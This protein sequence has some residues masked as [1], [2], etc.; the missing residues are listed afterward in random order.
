M[1]RGLVAAVLAAVLAVGTAVLPDAGRAAEQHLV[2]FDAVVADGAPPINGAMTIEVWA[3][4]GRQATVKVAE[5]HAAPAEVA[6]EPG[7]YRILTVYKQARRVHDIR[8]TADGPHRKTL[9]LGAGEIGLELLRRVGGAR[10]ADDVRWQVHE[11]ARGAGKGESVAVIEGSRP[12][13]LLREGWYE[14]VAR[15]DGVVTDHVVEVSA[16][17]RFDYSLVMRR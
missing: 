16:G 10:V 1:Q 2:R 15:H 14:V 5:R 6:L 11:Y 8:V 12:R 7:A 13:L 4:D 3:R 9:N 17:A